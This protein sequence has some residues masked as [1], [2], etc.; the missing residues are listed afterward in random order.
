MK[1][2]VIF[3]RNFGVKNFAGTGIRTQNLPTPFFFVAATT[4]NSGLGHDPARLGL[5]K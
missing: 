4:L 1:E 5:F 2:K 3:S